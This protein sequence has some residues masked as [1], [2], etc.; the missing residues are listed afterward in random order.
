MV[1][2]SVV[3]CLNGIKNHSIKGTGLGLWCLTPLLT[4]FQL[5]HGDKN[6]STKGTEK[7]TTIY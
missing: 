4:K 3:I 1:K 5:Y 2:V 7:H 6:L